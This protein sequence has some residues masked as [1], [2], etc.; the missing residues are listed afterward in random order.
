L[1]STLPDL[2]VNSVCDLPYCT[3]KQTL[4]TGATGKTFTDKAPLHNYTSW[5]EAGSVRCAQMLCA[6]IDDAVQA[7]RK[8]GKSQVARSCV[9]QIRQKGRSAIQAMRSLWP[10]LCL[11]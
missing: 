8:N 4:M 1:P 6:D 11:A 7:Q 3:D 10:A 2:A 5:P 9:R